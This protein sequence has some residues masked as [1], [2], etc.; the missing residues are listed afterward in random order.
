MRSKR[1]F[2]SG[3]RSSEGKKIKMFRQKRNESGSYVIYLK[4]RSQ[5]S[6][7]VFRDSYRLPVGVSPFLF[8]YFVGICRNV[9]IL[10]VLQRGAKGINIREHHI[11]HK[12]NKKT[13]ER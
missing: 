10:Y 9:F 5:R 7:L 13:K 6:S 12:K 4:S 11:K 1:K 3:P 8:A 2:S